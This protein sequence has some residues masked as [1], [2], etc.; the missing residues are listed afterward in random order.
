MHTGSYTLRGGSSSPSKPR[1]RVRSLEHAIGGIVRYKAVEWA[2]YIDKHGLPPSLA[3]HSPAPSETSKALVK[4]SADADVG[5]YPVVEAD[6]L[7]KILGLSLYDGEARERE[8]RR[9]VVCASS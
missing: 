5:Y 6:E 3:P 9:G 2:A 7:E 8:P 4:C 1:F